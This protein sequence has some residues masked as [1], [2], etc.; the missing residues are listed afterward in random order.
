MEPRGRFGP[1]LAVLALVV[2]AGGVV[3]GGLL[4]G[5]R[6]WFTALFGGAFG[7]AVIVVIVAG[8]RSWRGR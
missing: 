3:P 5:H 8:V 2:V 7:L 4:A 1:W 6:G